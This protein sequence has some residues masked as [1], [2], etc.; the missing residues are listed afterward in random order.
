[1]YQTGNLT[2]SGGS[3][4]GGSQ[5]WN[6]KTDVQGDYSPPINFDKNISLMSLKKKSNMDDCLPK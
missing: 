1:M 3:G 2:K 4:G 5:V 6:I